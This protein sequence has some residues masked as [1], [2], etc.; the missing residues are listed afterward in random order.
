MAVCAVYSASFVP[1]Q[2]A[3]LEN[4]SFIVAV[5]MIVDLLFCADIFMRLFTAYFDEKTG[6]YVTNHR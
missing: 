5:N 2:M 6:M 4:T 1:F 3:Y